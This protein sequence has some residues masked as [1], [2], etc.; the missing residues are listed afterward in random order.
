MTIASI[1]LTSGPNIQANLLEVSRYLK[2]ISKTNVKMV[3]LPENFALMP[4]NDQEFIE[5]AEI[6]GSG[7]LQDFL[8]QCS[9]KYKLW[10]IFCLLNL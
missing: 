9:E 3:V 8:S 6:E 2:D 10:I 7:P 5:H 4:E 1:Q